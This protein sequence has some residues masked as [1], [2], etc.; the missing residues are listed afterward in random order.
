MVSPRL[1]IILAVVGIIASGI[2]AR[3]IV[4]PPATHLSRAG[5]AS[6]QA[7]FN[8]DRRVHREKLFGGD[9]TRDISGGQEM[10]PRW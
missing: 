7:A 9:T 4:Q 10:K 8:V 1:F 2:V 6:P 5:E 3:W